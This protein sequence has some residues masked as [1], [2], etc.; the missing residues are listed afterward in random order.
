M[1]SAP[2]SSSLAEAV[3]AS[4]YN[5]DHI[6][7][8]N[9]CSCFAHFSLHR[10]NS[11]TMWQVGGVAP[12]L[13]LTALLSRCIWPCPR[14]CCSTLWRTWWWAGARWHFGPPQV[15]RSCWAGTGTVLPGR[16]SVSSAQGDSLEC[17]ASVAWYYD[18]KGQSITFSRTDN[19]NTRW[20]L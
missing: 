19:S 5:L 20:C 8:W 11:V 15:P 17:D 16:W 14:W 10:I 1:A 4:T 12:R 9:Q 2:V 13:L 3:R 6:K 18:S 7:W